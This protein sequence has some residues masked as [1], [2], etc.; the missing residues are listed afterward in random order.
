MAK[1]ILFSILFLSMIGS[2]IFAQGIMPPMPDEAQRDGFAKAMADNPE[3]AKF[4]KRLK[5]ISATI[6][7]TIQDYNKGKIS[8]DKARE[9]L[10]PLLK[11]QMAI[12]NDP[13]F[14]AEQALFAILSQK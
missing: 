3:L 10:R 8:K 6:G 9:I 1:K 5:E 13:D 14:L 7:A 2:P 4:Q 11:E 12:M